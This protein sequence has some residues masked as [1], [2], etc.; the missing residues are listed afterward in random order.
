MAL[1]GSAP[2]AGRRLAGAGHRRALAP[3]GRGGRGRPRRA[4]RRAGDRDRVGQVAGLPA[5]GADADPA[6]RA[7]ATAGA[8]R[9]C[10]TSP[11]PRRSPRTSS[12]SARVPRRAGPRRVHPRR[13]LPREQ[14]DWARD[15]A[16]YVLTNPDMLHHSLLPGHA[17]WSRFLGS[18]TLRRRRRV[19][20]LPRRLRRPRRAGPAPAAPRL[21]GL[22][23]HSHLRAGLRHRRGAGR[24]RLP[25]HRAAREQPSTDDGSARGE[26]T[27][28]LWEPPFTSY[29]RGER[30]ARPSLGRPPRWP[31][32]WPTWW[33][34]GVRTLAFV[35]SR[36]GAESVALTARR[37]LWTRSSP[38]LGD[39]V[40]AYR[41]GYLPEDRRELEQALRAGRLLGVAATNALELGIDIAGLDAVLMAG[42]PG[43]RA[44]M[45]QQVGRAGRGGQDALGV[46]VARD[47][48]LDTYLV[49]HPEA[50]VGRAGGGQRL[51]PGQ[52]LRPRTAPVRGGRRAAPHRG[53]PRPLRAAAPDRGSRPSPE[54]GCCAAGPRG[55][56]G[57]TAAGPATWPTCARPVGRRSASSRRAPGGCSA[58]WTRGPP[59]APSTTGRSTSTRARPTWSRS[60]TST[61][62]VATVRAAEPDYTTSARE[63]TDIAITGEREV[64]GVGQRSR[65]LGDGA[66]HPPGRL[67]TRKHARTGRGARGGAARPARTDPGHHGGLVDRSRRRS[68]TRRASIGRD[69]P[70]PHTPPSTPRSGCCPLFAT[71]DRWD[72]GGV[73]TALTPTPASSPSSSTTATPAAPASPSA[74]SAPPGLALRDA[75]GDPRLPMRRGMPVLRAVTQVRQQQR[76][77]RQGRSDRP[78]RRFCC[79]TPPSSGASSRAMLRGDQGGAPGAGA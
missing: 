42:F 40:A 19:P 17:R 60:S 68:S 14:R 73:S 20:P 77:P 53:G 57:P 71:C 32:C 27:L 67:L 72:I 21:R 28:A 22:R 4:A 45:W 50:L 9:R 36:R 55:G 18:L 12:A 63:I 13:R 59:T 69:L 7:T 66:G 70:A 38:G 43:T 37:R 48:P 49:T 47:D 29:A 79:A 1:P 61:T 5:A 76:A 52:P 2:A 8:A 24:V 25:A 11:R 54:P 62:G 56:S 16:E 44:A 31:T 26:V 3:P 64:A 6:S 41:G 23:R 46:L 33:S 74:A 65:G 58:P 51:R 34:S 78:A 10:S 75:R 30:R 35:R 39:R 15:H